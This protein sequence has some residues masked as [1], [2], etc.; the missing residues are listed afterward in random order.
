[1]QRLTLILSDLYL[2]EEAAVHSPLPRSMHLPA[3]DGL[4]RFAEAPRRI[5]GWRRWLACELEQT[6]LA[7]LPIAQSCARGQLEPVAAATA[8][9]ATP[10]RLEARLDHVRLMDRG[11]LRLEAEERTAWCAEFARAFG[12]EYALHDAGECGFLL[13]GLARTEARTVDPARLLDADIGPA[14]PAGPAAAELRRL[15]TEIEMWLH[16]SALNTVREQQR[17][18]R[19]A[20]L[21][22]WGGGMED[23]RGDA[24]TVAS[25]SASPRTVHCF[26]ADP[27]MASL[28]RAGAGI[29]ATNATYRDIE[30]LAGHAVVEQA[31]MSGPVEHA[32]PS[33]E[34]RWFAPARAAL[35]AGTLSMC[36]VIANDRWFR[37]RTGEHWKFWRRQVHW[38]KRL[39]TPT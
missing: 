10:V 35:R 18:P 16:T 6:A 26:G 27:F 33:I 20:A 31:P 24:A 23:S 2:P 17:L 8:W 22:L 30:N 4:L 14:L 19:I 38:L 34:A 3:L 32:L 7:D 1:M 9:L 21:W 28:A 39:A 5:D 15:G 29:G 13:I 11:L 12:P 25:H 36:D 37:I